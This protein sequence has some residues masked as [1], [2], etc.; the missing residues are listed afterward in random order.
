MAHVIIAG[1]GM[2]GLSLAWF[3]KN[4]AKGW[5][6][7]LL[8]ADSRVGGKAWTEKRDGFVIERGVNGVLDNKPS[9]LE[10]AAALG[11]APLR[12]NDASRIRFV[13]RDARLVALPSSPGQFLASPV[14]SWWGKARL[15]CEPL[16][17]P[18]WDIEDESL[19]QFARRR[20]GDEAYRYLID[21]MASGIYAGNPE[22]LS[23]KACFPRIHELEMEYGSLIWAMIKLQAQAKKAGKSGPN[24][25]PGGVLTS[26]PGG[27]EDLVSGLREALR[28]VIDTNARVEEIAPE[29]DGW[30][31]SVQDGRSFSGTHLV[32]S[33]PAFEAARIVK[34][35]LPSLSRLFSHFEYPPIAVCAFGIRKN[36]LDNALNGFGF[37]C[38]HCE[39]RKVLGALWDSSVFEKRAPEGYHLVRCLMGG[40]RNRH[41]LEKTDSQIM[42][43]ALTELKELIG[44]RG[45]PD[46]AMV[47]RW[48]RAI[49]QYH[50]G[51]L[52]LLESI[53]EEL[54]NF[55]NIFIRCNWIGGVSLNDCVANSKLVASAIVSGDDSVRF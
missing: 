21:P 4:S 30:Q 51:H 54:L 20:L 39:S 14:L 19:A 31:V 40:M 28:D 49:P 2:S 34:N 27:M 16:I 42:D 43:L 1:G 9:T 10:L 52:R 18:A 50:V 17:P 8:E 35:S 55:P 41:I 46:M 37:L 33:L 45:E 47:F 25:G 5:K 32:L 48:K 23:L 3:L 12:S 11:V 7:T 22:R 29:G 13:V 53:K 38:P 15:M 26:F 24:A 6:I 36:Q 44:L